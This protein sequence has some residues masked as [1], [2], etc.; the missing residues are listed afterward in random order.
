MSS[1]KQNTDL[2]WLELDLNKDLQTP[3]NIYQSEGCQ[4]AAVESFQ[5]VDSSHNIN[6]TNLCSHNKGS[7]L[8]DQTINDEEPSLVHSNC[9]QIKKGRKPFI[10]GLRKRNDIVLKSI[11]RK[12][13][14]FHWER[15]KKTT[16]FSTK[17][18]SSKQ[19]QL[20]YLNIYIEREFGVEPNNQFMDTL[21]AV[22]FMKDL[23][24]TKYNIFRDLFNSYSKKKLQRWMRDPY[25][26]CMVYHYSFENDPNELDTDALTG[27]KVILNSE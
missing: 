16:S 27:I 10:A 26:K 8:E 20:E 6:I 22:F 23:K 1:H 18:R 11:L 19:K 21:Y 17:H 14:K 3:I 9:T 4:N 13:R 24:T 5:S 15:F 7:S 2:S 12:V 25:F